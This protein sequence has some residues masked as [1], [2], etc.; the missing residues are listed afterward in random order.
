[1]VCAV[2]SVDRI[3]LNLGASRKCFASVRQNVLLTFSIALVS[4]SVRRA[5]TLD[6]LAIGAMCFTV[7]VCGIQ[8]C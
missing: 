5:L 4:S 6:A 7:Y 2:R 3:V 8:N 1:M